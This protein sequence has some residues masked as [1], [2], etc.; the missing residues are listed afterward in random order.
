[1]K[2]I[3]IFMFTSVLSF[4]ANAALVD[5]GG[6]LIYDST[7]NITWLQDANY[8][9][10]SGYD[11]DGEMS[12][13]AASSWVDGLSYGGHDDWR[14]PTTVQPD[15]SCTFTSPTSWGWN[16]TGSEM[17]NLYY[18]TLGNAQFDDISLINTGPF[19]NVK[20]EY[21]SGTAHPAGSGTY[22]SFDFDG[23]MQAGS[24][25][26]EY[27]WAVADGNIAASVVPIPA[28]VYLFASGLGLLGWMRRKVS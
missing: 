20:D 3:I 8:A 9:S 14:L 13:S 25:F 4:N 18:T 2:K 27:A 1:M 28:A 23:G 7:Q 17:G 21:H 26:D 19:T 5:N 10:T 22:W 15:S 6:G 11:A 24:D 12:W 16:C